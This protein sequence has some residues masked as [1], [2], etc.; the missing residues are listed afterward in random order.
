ML[1]TSE[2]LASRTSVWVCFAGAMTLMLSFFNIA[3][4]I[5]ALVNDE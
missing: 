4:G 2:G 5:A 3:Y 1:T